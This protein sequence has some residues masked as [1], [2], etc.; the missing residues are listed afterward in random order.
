MPIVFEC[1]CGKQ[2]RAKDTSAGKAFTCP[3]CNAAIE[4]PSP[5]AI[6]LGID[7]SD[8]ADTTTDAPP[9]VDP[10]AQTEPERISRADYLASRR[11]Y[12]SP[13]ESPPNRV[14]VVDF[15]MPFESLVMFL[16]KLE[17]ALVLATFLAAALVGLVVGIPL[18]LILL[19]LAA[20]GR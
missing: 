1:V 19:L 14:A 11:R 2:L 4:V 7:L 3:A 20:F 10:P 17:F 8:K 12:A 15:S 5:G 18:G 16:V 6:D 13:I 9:A